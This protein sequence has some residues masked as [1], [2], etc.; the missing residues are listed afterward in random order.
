MIGVLN[1]SAAS[2]IASSYGVAG[3]HAIERAVR[4]DVVQRHAFGFKKTLERADLV[5]DAIGKLLASDLHFATAEALP[6][7]QRRMR[8]DSDVLLLGKLHCPAH[9]VEVGGVEAAGN[10]GDGDRGHHRS[11]SPSR[12][13]PKLSPISQFKRTTGVSV[14]VECT[15]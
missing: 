6:V 15:R 9:V 11:S 13:M 8:S 2:Q 5:D 12:Q 10:V 14:V 1:T 4:L 7:R 3:G